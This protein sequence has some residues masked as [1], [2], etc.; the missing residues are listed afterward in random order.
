MWRKGHIEKLWNAYHFFDNDDV[1]FYVI[2]RC[3]PCKKLLIK[4]YIFKQN[5]YANKAELKAVGWNEKYPVS[6]DTE[7]SKIDLQYIPDVTMVEQ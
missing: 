7:L 3:G 2:F 4:T 6:L 1:E 5:R